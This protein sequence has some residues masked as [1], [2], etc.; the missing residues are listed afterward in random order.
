MFINNKYTRIYYNIINKARSQDIIPGELYEKHHIIPRSLGGSNL[1]TNLIKLTL[2]QH[3]LCHWLLCKMT[4]GKDRSKMVYAFN[5]FRTSERLKSTRMYEIA[6]KYFIETNKSQ[7]LGENNPMYGRTGKLS[8]VAK[9]ILFD[10]KTF[11]SKSSM[12]DYVRSNTNI[13]WYSG[14]L[15]YYKNGAR[16]LNTMQSL[17]NISNLNSK[18][19]GMSN[20]GNPCLHGWKMKR[21]YKKFNKKSKRLLKP[22]RYRYC[23]SFTDDLSLYGIKTLS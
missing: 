8:P 22:G 12:V 21:I 9:S 5:R 13:K 17:Y 6:R 20:K 10:G 3:A 23:Y 2:R 18:T 14:I 1:P 4:V 7:F 11:H 19:A 15:K 16:D